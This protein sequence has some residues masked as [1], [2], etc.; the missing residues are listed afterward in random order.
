M[1]KDAPICSRCGKSHKDDEDSSSKRSARTSCAVP[2]AH[3]TTPLSKTEDGK[4]SKPNTEPDLL[5]SRSPSR[6]RCTSP[7]TDQLWLDLCCPT[8]HHFCDH[9]GLFLLILVSL[10]EYGPIDEVVPICVLEC[11]RVHR[12]MCSSSLSVGIEL[13][14]CEVTQRALLAEMAVMQEETPAMEP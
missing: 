11:T 2:S 4:H 13:V 6:H 8:P 14:V 12:S 1:A 5:S 3:T 7:G 10:I 9:F